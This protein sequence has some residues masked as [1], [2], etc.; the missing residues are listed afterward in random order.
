MLSPLHFLWDASWYSF[1]SRNYFSQLL[2]KGGYIRRINSGIYAYANNGVI[3]KISNIIEKELNTNGCSKL[4][5]STT[6][7]RFVE[8]SERWE[9]YTAGEG[10]MLNLKIGKERIWISP[11]S[12][13]GNYKSLQKLLIHITAAFMLL[14]N[15]N[16]V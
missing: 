1:W 9:G 4:L 14:P 7:S 10:I 8:K 6:S 5:C 2:L 15:S 11:N 12:W 13:R 3:E 16:K